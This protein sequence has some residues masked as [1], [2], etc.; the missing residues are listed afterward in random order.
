MVLCSVS[1]RWSHTGRP[2]GIFLFMAK[3]KNSFILYADQISVFE[4]LTDDE[5]GRLIKHI[6]RYINDQDPECPDK[7][8]KIAF[9]P[10]K[11][12]LKRDLKD[13]EE[14]RQ[15]RSE[16]G[17]KGMEKRWAKGNEVQQDI[18]TDNTVIPAI[19]NIT[20]NV[21]VNVTV[22]DNVTNTELVPEKPKPAPETVEQR[23][24]KFAQKLE[25]WKEKYGADMLNAFY[26][27][28][29]E[30]GEQDRKMRFE[31][32]T[33]FDVVL[34]LA[35]WH[36]RQKEKPSYSNTATQSGGR[37]PLDPNLAKKFQKNQ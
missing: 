12:Q 20:D 23:K 2:D 30:R 10:I 26:L 33:V 32:E 7:L 18:T 21:N 35:T 31:K 22:N 4:E 29:T 9:E 13:W 8:T 28:W 1:F 19:T 16:A 17:K 25:P 14:K 27:Y 37:Y 24:Q 11:Q 36:R 3:D 5:A 15:Q 34:R 6:F